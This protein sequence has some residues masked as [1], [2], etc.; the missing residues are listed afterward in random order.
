ML[1]EKCHNAVATVHITQI[2]NGKKNEEHLCSKCAGEAGYGWS[3]GW[4]DIGDF[5]W[6]NILP[7]YSSP[8]QANNPVCP[9]CG[10]TYQGFLSTGKLGCSKCYSTFGERL[11]PTIQKI[12]G[13]IHHLGKVPKVFENKQDN[14]AVVGEKPAAKKRL[15]QKDKLQ[16]ELAKLIQEERFEEA[17]VV[18]DKIKAL[19]KKDKGVS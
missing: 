17:A 3:S 11:K 2:V 8:T 13:S 19:E 1:C 18:R 12:H 14:E 9:L 10:T 5:G 6:Q 7:F 4:S 16:V 15:S